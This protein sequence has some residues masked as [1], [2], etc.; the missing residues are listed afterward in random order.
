MTP[1][2]LV[3]VDRERYRRRARFVLFGRFFCPSHL[4]SS[5]RTISLFTSNH[6]VSTSC[7]KAHWR[8][9]PA[10]LLCPNSSTSSQFDPCPEFQLGPSAGTASGPRTPLAQHG[11][12]VAPDAANLRRGRGCCY[13]GHFQLSKVVLECGSQ[14]IIRATDV[15]ACSGDLGR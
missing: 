9:L 7:A 2:R 8:P 15:A 6:N 4:T 14:Y 12:A 11:A 10:E 1:S 5:L 3:G 13:D